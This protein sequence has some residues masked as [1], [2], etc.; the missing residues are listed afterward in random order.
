[1]PSDSVL[2]KAVLSTV[3]NETQ[4]RLTRQSCTGLVT[5]HFFG[6]QANG[7]H[8]DVDGMQLTGFAQYQSPHLQKGV[9]GITETRLWLFRVES[10]RL[11]KIYHGQF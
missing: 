6:A 3:L 10:K 1:M 5:V 8:G 11:S 7:L 4:L 2:R 9:R